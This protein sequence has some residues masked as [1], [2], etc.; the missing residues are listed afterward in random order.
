MSICP[1]LRFPCKGVIKSLH[2][3]VI[4]HRHYGIDFEASV[5][6]TLGLLS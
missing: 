5:K 2:F 6:T 1:T 3:D 4:E